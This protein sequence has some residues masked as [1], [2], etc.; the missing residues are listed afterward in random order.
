MNSRCSSCINCTL[1]FL[2]YP[3]SDDI[4]HWETDA[5]NADVSEG[6]EHLSLTLRCTQT[7]KR[8]CLYDSMCMMIVS[9]MK[10]STTR[11]T[12][13]IYDDCICTYFPESAER[14]LGRAIPLPMVG[15]VVATNARTYCIYGQGEY[16]WVHRMHVSL[17]LFFPSLG[18]WV[19]VASSDAA[20]YHSSG[21]LW[22]FS[23]Y[24]FLLP[25][26]TIWKACLGRKSR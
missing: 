25:N 13:T 21:R 9:A 5:F 22:D 14:V 18:R 4:T 26:H 16:P 24:I 17:S 23:Y 15:V 1:E 11:T 3:W 12:R 8:G 20:L 6:R 19:H 2:N 10:E 7:G